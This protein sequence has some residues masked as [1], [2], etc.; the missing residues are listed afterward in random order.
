MPSEAPPAIANLLEFAARQALA[1][2][3]TAYFIGDER[4]DP[5]EL[6]ASPGPV[7]LLTKTGGTTRHRQ[8]GI[9]YIHYNLEIPSIAL[10]FS[11]Y[12]KPASLDPARNRSAVGRAIRYL[13]VNYN[14]GTIF[15]HEEPAE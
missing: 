2:T 4:M 5:L 15:I 8:Q 10:E 7:I 3:D 12:I 9:N 11:F 14:K 1:V 6:S 13:I